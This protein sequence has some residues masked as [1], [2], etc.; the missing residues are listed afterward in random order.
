MG[1]YLMCAL[2]VL[3]AT[4]GPGRADVPYRGPEIPHPGEAPPPPAHSSSH[5]VLVGL[6]LSSALLLLGV[7]IIRRVQFGKPR[8]LGAG[9]I[10]FLLALGCAI[11]AGSMFVYDEIVIANA[12]RE[13][14]QWQD[15][16]RRWEQEKINKQKW[17]EESLR[18]DWEW[19]KGPRKERDGT[20]SSSKPSE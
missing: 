14:K 1:K 12:D 2:L 13:Y 6:G 9:L 8:F 15:Q 16:L 7:W 11:T 10:C 20:P 19:K 17:L 18:R 4:P 3:L 5:E